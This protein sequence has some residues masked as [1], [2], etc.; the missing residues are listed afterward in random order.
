MSSKIDK[1]L[2]A[3]L[4]SLLFFGFYFVFVSL[5][6]QSEVE[7]T[8]FMEWDK[9]IDDSID[10]NLKRIY[11]DSQFRN[12]KVKLENEELSG[13]FK[14]KMKHW[15]PAQ[16]KYSEIYDIDT[17]QSEVDLSS[18]SSIEEQLRNQ[19]E[20]TRRQKQQEILNRQEY[21][22]KFKENARKD[23]WIVELNKDLEVISAKKSK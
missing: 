18:S 15:T 9:K 8:S 4:F 5:N 2:A 21:I 7:S 19:M 13:Q 1:V 10:R 14:T 6:S 3:L 11:Y 23:G 17:S 20:I 12:F 22:R 16:E